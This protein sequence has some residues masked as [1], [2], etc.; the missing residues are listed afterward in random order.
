VHQL[1]AAERTDEIARMLGGAEVSD[2][3]RRAAKELLMR[4]G[5]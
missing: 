2:K 4:A 3:F 1:E 5:A